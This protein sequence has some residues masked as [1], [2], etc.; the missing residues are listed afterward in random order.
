MSNEN[1][2][3]FPSQEK[4]ERHFLRINYQ[5]IVN[6]IAYDFLKKYQSYFE[7]FSV[8]CLHVLLYALITIHGGSLPLMSLIASRF[9]LD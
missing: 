3:P 5:S 9:Q 2:R 6:I 8:V 1:L 4:S 7:E